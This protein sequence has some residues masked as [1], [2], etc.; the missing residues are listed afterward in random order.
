MKL[1]RSLAFAA[2]LLAP[3]FAFAQAPPPS[4]GA[5]QV[6]NTCI[7]SLT[8]NVGGTATVA[9]PASVN[10]YFGLTLKN[11]GTEDVWVAQG[12]ST[13][14]ATTSNIPI[15][16]GES[17]TISVLPGATTI[18]AK[19]AA[20]T[21]QIDIY[22]GSGGV[23]L[24]NPAGS[25]GGGGGTV[26]QGNPNGGGAL[27]W[28]VNLQDGTGNPL[29]STAGALDV[30]CT[31]GCSSGSTSNAG[32][33][34][35]TSSTNAPTVAYDYFFNGTTWDQ[36]Q[37][38]ASK[39]LKVNV[40]A[41]SVTANAGTNLNTS[42]LATDAHLTSFTS[43]NHT[44]LGTINTTLGLFQAADGAAAP[45][46][47]VVIGSI[48]GSGNTQNASA[49][50]PVPVVQTGTPALPTGAST[51]ALQPTNAAQ[52]STTSGQTGPLVQCATVS[53]APTNTN[54]QTN[55][56]NCGTDGGLVVEGG[57]AQGSTTSGQ[58]LS[59]IG[60][61]V[62]TAAPSY[63]TAQTGAISLDTAGN[64]RTNCVTG[65]GSS[66]STGT[67][68]AA[69]PA[70]ATYVAANNGGNLTGLTSG[71]NGLNVS[72]NAATPVSGNLQ[73]SATA[74]GNGSPLA[75][76]AGESSVVIT[77]PT[78]STGSATINFEDSQNSTTGANGD[79]FAMSCTKQDG[80]NTIASSTSITGI[81]QWQCPVAGET[82]VRAR[83]SGYGSGSITIPASATPVDWNSRVV[84][85][86]VVNTP[87]VTCAACM[88][89]SG[90][91]VAVTNLPTTVDTNS[92]A[93][94]ASTIRNVPAT[95]T[96]CTLITP[97]NQTT[98]TDIY[99]S[100]AKIHVCGLLV[101]SATA[102]NI[103]L[104]EGTG[105]VCATGIAALIGGTT[106]SFAAAANGG[107]AQAA[108]V[109]FFQSKTAADHICLLQSSSGNISGFLSYADY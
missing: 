102:Q 25:G 100:T 5:A 94:G 4:I 71:A 66:A 86:N 3:S 48:D 53:S 93:P 29:G 79:Y 17:V 19:S 99:T 97:I 83:I 91:S 92:G 76:G 14:T 10:P 56:L 58:K 49:S 22:Q 106:A 69:V 63:T 41:G 87:A 55:A 107:W 51:S 47:A 88:P 23:L 82:Y 108:G 12:I 67:T 98:S 15:R 61:A 34:V 32:S 73:T 57:V 9:L 24:Q 26:T 28:F 60:G 16:S 2:A 90:G 36:A 72:Q 59:L 31:A 52:G 20:A 70:S 74:S 35:A 62:T 13:I 78:G 104:V 101:N 42:A 81:S 39:N 80:T 75:I 8:A 77:I 43:A 85:A 64:V 54:A 109:P 45:P 33:G 27:G 1:I 50:T 11:N 105:T 46:N 89:S 40:E 6:C 38:D 95:V 30:D 68:G 7:A 21:S 103:S 96:A 37:G 44:D 84:N 18:A 65:C